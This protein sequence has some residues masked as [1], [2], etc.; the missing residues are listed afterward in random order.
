M[1]Q[2]SRVARWT[3][4]LALLSAGPGCR[5][6][7]RARPPGPPG[8][9][10]LLAST[11]TTAAGPGA[12]DVTP[13]IEVPAVAEQLTAAF[14]GAAEAIR[15]SVV[16][17]DVVA[18]GASPAQGRAQGMPPQLPDFFERFFDFGDRGPPA[19]RRG[20]GSGFVLDRAGHILT[21]SHVV[22]NA[23][24]VRVQ[25][26]DG[27]TFGARIVG[28][29][30]LTDLAVLRPNRTPDNL[31]VARTG[32]S[33]KLRVGQ[34]VLA[35][36]SP[37]GLEQSVTAGIVSSLGRTGGR[38][39]MSGERVRRY[40]QTDAAINPGNSGG[41][42][43]TLAGEVIGVNTLINVGPGGAYGFAIPMNQA[44]R[45]AQALMKE[46]RVRYPFIGVE[47]GSVGD[48]TAEARAQLGGGAPAEGAFV[49]GVVP[50]GPA[51]QAGLRA[52]DIIVK[53]DGGAI[54]DGAAL[55]EAVST[56]TIGSKLSLQYWRDGRSQTTQLVVGELPSRLAT[57]TPE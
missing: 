15:P 3:A 36:G 33:E 44:V 18:S 23:Q 4:L 34:W 25:L 16:R 9:Q 21:N 30:P 28:R 38:I 32:D 6:E 42:L 35:V 5:R 39:R 53:I 24:Q 45:V 57:S 40:I 10:T 48:L 13:R 49:G 46:G 52:G 51:D 31:T 50:G 7:D 17:I 19:P 1:N 26:T 47:V 8:K 29:D 55:L 11:T 2:I 56:H 12:S 54:P 20:V 37:L 14:A 22:E 27:R 41:P 43:V